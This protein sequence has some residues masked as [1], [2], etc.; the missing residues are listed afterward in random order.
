M[1][2]NC[3]KRAMIEIAAL[4]TRRNLLRKKQIFFSEE[5]NARIFTQSRV[6]EIC[7][8]RHPTGLQC[9]QEKQN[10]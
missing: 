2:A 9:H 7:S 6:C 8:E 5:S 10:R 3:L 4:N 1:F